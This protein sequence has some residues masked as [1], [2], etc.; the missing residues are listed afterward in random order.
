V[1]ELSIELPNRRATR[2]LAQALAAA[3]APG[4]TP[5]PI[6]IDDALALLARFALLERD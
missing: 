6:Q 1:S 4:A 5:T 3:L 2:R